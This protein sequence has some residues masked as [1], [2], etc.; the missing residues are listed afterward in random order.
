MSIIP[1]TRVDYTDES[2]EP[3]ITSLLLNPD[4]RRYYVL[5][6][7][8]YN[9]ATGTTLTRWYSSGI[10]TV[11][12]FSGVWKPR[13]VDAFNVATDLF[14]GPFGLGGQGRPAYGT[15]SIAIGDEVERNTILRDDFAWLDWHRRNVTL[16]MGGHPD[17]GW[18]WDDYVVIFRGSSDEVTWDEDRLVLI[19]RDP[20][21]KLNDPVQG[22]LYLGTGNDEGDENM[23]GQPKPLAFG[24]LRNVSPVLVDR[25][26]LIYQLHDGPIVAIDAVYDKG[27][28]YT[29]DGD[30]PGPITD[31]R[32][33]E[34]LP[35]ETGRYITDLAKGLFRLSTQPNGALT[36][37]LQG[38]SDGGTL[39]EFQGSLI[40]RILT[41]FCD[42]T[43]A[44]L[45]LSSIGQLDATAREVA[46]YITQSTP[47]GTVVDS[48]LAP[49]GFRT[50]NTT[51]QLVVGHVQFRTSILTLEPPRIVS[52]FRDRT[53]PPLW[54]LSLGYAR[55]WTLMDEA[56]LSIAEDIALDADFATN[57]W[58]R[59]VMSDDTVRVRN[60]S[61]EDKEV[62][63]L[64]VHDHD[65]IHEAEELFNLYRYDRDFYRVTAA[66]IQ[67]RVR[68]GQ[69]V[70]LKH[71][72]FG[73]FDGRGFIVMTIA[74]NTTLGTTELVL[75][76]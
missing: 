58:R 24:R 25:L 22:T 62:D 14:D 31:L 32:D 15:I 70:K 42:W 64:F 61:A 2:T 51:G 60:P 30:L 5:K 28:A 46:I 68:V 63:S 12:G 38:D 55:N 73:L 37:D 67:F 19:I 75:W 40:R 52:I 20:T 36:V 49:H 53:P 65:A 33:Y 41:G 11:P 6:V 21:V 34:W 13:L 17:D 18:T 3:L 26:N 7:E 16:Y 50:Y 69:T 56:D 8:P 39:H 4:A 72:R 59:K 54:R 45:D 44:E 1:M 74:E 47:V 27:E 43:D 48:L 9:P 29:S 71:P 35:S 10:I 66:R 57:E 76:G 23:E